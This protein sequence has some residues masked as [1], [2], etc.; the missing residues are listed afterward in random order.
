MWYPD[1]NALVLQIRE[2]IVVCTAFSSGKQPDHHAKEQPRFPA[3]AVLQDTRSDYQANI[4]NFQP[5]KCFSGDFFDG[6]PPCETLVPEQYMT[7]SSCSCQNSWSSNGNTSFVWA[8]TRSFKYFL[9]RPPSNVISKRPG[10]VMSLQ[11]YFDCTCPQ[12]SFCPNE[13]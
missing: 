11:V 8:E 2:D 7:M 12:M 6:A 5:P 4:V 13:L 3:V 9:L 10:Y 1:L